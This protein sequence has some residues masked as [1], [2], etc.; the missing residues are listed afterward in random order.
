MNN[1]QA[2]HQRISELTSELSD[3]EVK[4]NRIKYLVQHQIKMDEEILKI[5]EK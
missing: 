2:A 1:L 3:K 5:L 4:L